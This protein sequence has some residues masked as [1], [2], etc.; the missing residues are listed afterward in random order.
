MPAKSTTA[1]ASADNA[2]FMTEQQLCE[3]IG[4]HPRTPK[5]WRRDGDGPAYSRLGARM[6]RY[7]IQDV[8]EW[9]A[10]RSFAHR[11]AEAVGKTAT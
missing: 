9:I 3:M 5:R 11:A 10:A 8:N 4:V 6:I 2:E 1:K 7:R